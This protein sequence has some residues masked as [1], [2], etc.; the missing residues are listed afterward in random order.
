ME[1][2]LIFH[3][4]LSVDL[5]CGGQRMLFVLFLLLEVFTVG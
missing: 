4:L 1:G 3:F 2:N 5:V